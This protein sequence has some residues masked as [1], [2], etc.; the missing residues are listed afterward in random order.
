METTLHKDDIK[1]SQIGNAISAMTI[2]G[3]VTDSDAIVDRD[4]TLGE[5]Q[6]DL[7][8]RQSE[9][10]RRSVFL[11]Q[12]GGTSTELVSGFTA[13][14]FVWTL[15][16]QGLSVERRGNARDNIDAASVTDIEIIHDILRKI[17]AITM[18]IDCGDWVDGSNM[19]SGETADFRR[20]KYLC[21][22]INP[23]S[24]LTE[25]HDVWKDGFKWRCIQNEPVN[26]T[27]YPPTWYNTQYWKM[28]EGDDTVDA[29]ITSSNGLSFR[30]G[31]VDTTVKGYAF[32]GG[33]DISEDPG[34]TFSW[35]RATVESGV[36]YVTPADI[37]WGAQHQGE[38]VIHL[39][40]DDMPAEWTWTRLPAFTLSVEVNDGKQT[41]IVEDQWWFYC[42]M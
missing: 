20:G 32:Y 14:D 34:V 3:I 11:A 4:V 25:T 7:A 1:Y 41:T 42:T 23:N 26:G 18:C 33:L 35:K 2:D 15:P 5:L 10:N 8:Y 37:A 21:E 31:Y 39:T 19:P 30:K 13:N 40:D 12:S 28:I 16:E 17:S 27:Y 22:S 6:G 9:L 38:R 36:T 29:R 24:N